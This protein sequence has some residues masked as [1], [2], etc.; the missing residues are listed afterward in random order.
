MTETPEG[1]VWR[2][3]SSGELPTSRAGRPLPPPGAPPIAAT[4]PPSGPL[5]AQVPLNAPAQSVSPGLGGTLQGFF[6]AMCGLSIVA[7]LLAIGNLLA[8]NAWWDTPI[9]SREADDA[10]DDWVRVE[11]ALQAVGGVMLIVGI[12]VFVLL[13][14]WSNRAHAASQ[15]L[16][17]G[18]RTWSSGWSVGGWFIPLGNAVIPKM[19]LDEIERIA[20]AVRSGGRADEAWRTVSTSAVGWVWW[21]AMIVGALLNVAGNRLGTELGASAAE[22]RLGYVLNCVGLTVSAVGMAAGAVFVRKLTSR[23]TAEGLRAPT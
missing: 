11:D 19:V 6:W 3:P 22:V 12:V 17:L 7:L 13:V 1:P 21:L 4:R 10:L 9:G 20:F 5:A 14:V 8:F 16:W 2:P 23:L 18:E 15:E